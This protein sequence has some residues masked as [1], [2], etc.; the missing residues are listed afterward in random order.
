MH[1]RG[2]TRGKPPQKESPATRQVIHLLRELLHSLLVSSAPAWVDLSLT[3]PQLRVLFV[4]AHGGGCSV[5]HIARD[6]HIGEPTASHLVDRLVKAGL[7]HRDEDPEDRRR[8]LVGLSAAGEGLIGRLLGWEHLLGAWLQGIPSRD[9]ASLRDGLIAITRTR[10]RAVTG[11]IHT[12]RK[13]GGV[14]DSSP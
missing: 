11:G 4:V 6:L 13:K 14:K 8:V 9:L 10:S 2:M 5:M 1:G 3:L 12:S 7:V